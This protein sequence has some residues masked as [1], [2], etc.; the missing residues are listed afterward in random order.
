MAQGVAQGVAQG[1]AE[2]LLTMLGRRFGEPSAETISR[3][4]TAGVETLDRWILRFVDASS[5][6]EIFADR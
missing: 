1:K 6:D 5:L 3:I 4:R 2:T